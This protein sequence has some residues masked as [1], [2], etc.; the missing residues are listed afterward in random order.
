MGVE[1]LKVL[2]M[3]FL[4]CGRMKIKNVFLCVCVC[5]CGEIE[6]FSGAPGPAQVSC[7][8]GVTA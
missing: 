8:A 2:E 5:V 7:V 3:Y 4:V 6:N 1:R